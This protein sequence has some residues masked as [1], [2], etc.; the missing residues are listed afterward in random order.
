M[1][2]QLAMSQWSKRI[3]LGRWTHSCCI[4]DTSYWWIVGNY[5]YN[6]GGDLFNL[7]RGQGW[8]KLHMA[9]D[10]DQSPAKLIWPFP[11]ALIGFASGRVD[12]RSYWTSGRKR[13][14]RRMR[15]CVKIG[16]NLTGFSCGKIY[17]SVGWKI[18]IVNISNLG[19]KWLNHSDCF[20][21]FFFFFLF[22]FFPPPL[23]F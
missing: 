17:L 14:G 16:R 8:F 2:N 11:L 6:V 13:N 23:W 1:T 19:S 15:W 12:R 20:Q 3:T 18:L 9:Q 21:Q 5:W 4:C 10:L 7:R 22:Y